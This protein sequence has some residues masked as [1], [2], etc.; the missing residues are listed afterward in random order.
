M[1]LPEVSF[2]GAVF[3]IAIVIIRTVTINKLPKKT[4]LILWKVVL[5]R[6]LIPFAIPSVFSVYTLM[7]T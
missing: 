3:I 7:N 5:L 2:S 4:F 1:T 6:L